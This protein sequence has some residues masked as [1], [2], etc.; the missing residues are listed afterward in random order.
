MVKEC[1]SFYANFA[2]VSE[3]IKKVPLFTPL[4]DWQLRQLTE[5]LKTIQ[6]APGQ[7]VIREGETGLD[8]FLVEVRNPRPIVTSS[9]HPHLILTSSSPHLHLILIILTSSSSTLGFRRGSL[10]ARRPGFTGAICCAS[11]SV[12]STLVSVRCWCK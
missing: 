7:V 5:S 1:E 6:I 11:M 10:H 2:R 9:P 8:M 4:P 12:V 3:V